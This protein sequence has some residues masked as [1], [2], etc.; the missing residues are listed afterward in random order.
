ME[1]IQT[2]GSFDFAALMAAAANIGIIAGKAILVFIVC[3][4]AMNLL[5]KAADGIFAKTKLDAGITGFARSV[6][7]I[8]LWALTIIIV[9]ESL[10]I[11]TASLVAIVSV[12]SLALSL[13]VQ[14]ILTNVFS[15]I[16]PI[17][18]R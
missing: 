11:N 8:A 4:I 14:N 16:S 7:K 17:P 13:S 12:A 10:G 2:A 6:V 15:G 9:A 5:M 1:L 3:R 18:P